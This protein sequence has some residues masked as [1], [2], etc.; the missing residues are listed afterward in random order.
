[1]GQGVNPA[2]MGLSPSQAALSVGARQSLVPASCLTW[3]YVMMGAGN[4]YQNRADI[5]PYFSSVLF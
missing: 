2:T 1:M 3:L 5:Q 4:G